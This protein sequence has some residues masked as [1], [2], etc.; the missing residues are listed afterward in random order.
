[1]TRLYRKNTIFHRMHPSHQRPKRFICPLRNTIA[2]PCDSTAN[3]LAVCALRV[4]RKADE[5]PNDWQTRR[6]ATTLLLPSGRTAV[7]SRIEDSAYFG[8][9][10]RPHYASYIG[11][12][13]TVGLSVS[14]LARH[15][16]NSSSAQSGLDGHS[17]F[18]APCGGLTLQ[19]HRGPIVVR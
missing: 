2:V 4:L 8:A 16:E 1:L 14:A 15:I 5:D 12:N 11:R 10:F 18:S 17:E 7:L 19:F 3:P 13:G 6:R 9:E